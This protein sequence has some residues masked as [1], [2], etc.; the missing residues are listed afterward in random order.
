MHRQQH[1]SLCGLCACVRACVR[2][3]VHVCVHA[4]QC[5]VYV[6]VCVSACMRVCD[7]MTVHGYVIQ[8]VFDYNGNFKTGPM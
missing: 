5:V 7:I 2:A 1:V 6:C 8:S 4:C 3:C